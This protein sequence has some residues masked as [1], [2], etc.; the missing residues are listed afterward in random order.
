L[1]NHTEVEALR[2]GTIRGPAEDIPPVFDHIV[3]SFLVFRI[4]P[5]HAVIEPAG[6]V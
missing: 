3:A 1:L 5:A 2:M 4:E 6:D